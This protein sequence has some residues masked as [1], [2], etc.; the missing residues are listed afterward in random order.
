MAKASRTEEH[1]PENVESILSKIRNMVIGKEKIVLEER[2]APA[3][4]KLDDADIDDSE[5]MELTEIVEVDETVVSV[6]P[7]SNEEASQDLGE[8]SEAM[9]LVEESYQAAAEP[10]SEKFVDI[11]E[12]IDQALEAEYSAA[13][14][15]AVAAEAE[16][17]IEPAP[18]PEV[19][20]SANVAVQAQNIAPEPVEEKKEFS[21]PAPQATIAEDKISPMAEQK[22]NILSQDIAEKSSRAIQNLIDS[23][24]RTSIDSPAFRSAVTLE[25]M[26]L[27]T[28]RPLLKEWLDKN[29]E[30]IVRDIV[31]R[32]IKKIIPR[33]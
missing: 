7:Q 21:Q 16:Q 19:Q 32:E 15:E 20:E 8:I 31:E 12:E 11:L 17:V 25:D 18:E 5:P 27:E 28:I 26:A 30:T 6:T 2:P 13:N 10:E 33:D 4:I 22:E 24:P 9:A 14:T 23:V 3:A 29:L 1:Q